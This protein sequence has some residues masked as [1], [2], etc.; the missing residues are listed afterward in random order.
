VQLELEV[1][2]KTTWRLYEEDAVDVTLDAGEMSLHHG[3][4]FHASH[5]NRTED[6][7]I[8]VAFRYIAPS[9][10]QTHARKVTAMQARGKDNYGHFELMEPPTSLFAPEDI[11]RLKQIFTA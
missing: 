2:R 10:R 1:V 6:R 4:T 3:R 9:M 7:R 8:G 5:S 11:V